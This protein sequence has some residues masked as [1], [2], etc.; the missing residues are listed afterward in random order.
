[1]EAHT[2]IP[3][4]DLS[5]IVWTS[6]DS[7]PCDDCLVLDLSPRETSG[8]AVTLVSENGCVT[9][10]EVLIFVE[11]KKRI[12]IPNAF[13]PDNDGNNDVF[14][15]YGGSGVEEVEEF[16]IF[17]RW[18]EL[19]FEQHHFQPNDPLYGWNGFFKGKKLNPA[20]FIYFAKIKYINGESE[21]IKGDLFLK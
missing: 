10:D 2:N 17:N 20:V 14:M 21:I 9:E 19:L 11:N 7:I 3:M 6:S 16:M 12:F 1:L 15:I 18:G 8:Y 5:E 4:S 13:S